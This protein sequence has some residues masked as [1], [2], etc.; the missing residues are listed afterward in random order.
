M[1]QIRNGMHLF[2][3]NNNTISY[4]NSDIYYYTDY[5][6][7]KQTRQFTVCSH[8]SLYETAKMVFSITAILLAKILHT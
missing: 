1:F 7:Q 3:Y 4:N 6:K 5:L 2:L 8:T